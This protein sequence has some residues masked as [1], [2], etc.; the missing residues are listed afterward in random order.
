MATSFVPDPK[1]GLR[2]LGWVKQFANVALLSACIA[3]AGAASAGVSPQP[4]PTG[5][6]IYEVAQGNRGW[7]EIARLDG[8]ARRRLTQLPGSR[9]NRADVQ[10]TWSP[11][12]RRVAF[13]RFS[14][15]GRLPVTLYVVQL[16]GRGLRRIGPASSAPYVWS[17]NSRTLAFSGPS[18][19]C[20]PWKRSDVPL[21]VA[22]VNGAGLRR[23]SVVP[24][25]AITTFAEP[26]DLSPTSQTLLYIVKRYEEHECLENK[27]TGSDLDRIRIGEKKR[28]KLRSGAIGQAEWSPDGQKIAFLSGFGNRCAVFVSAAS[29]RSLRRLVDIP[30]VYEGCWNARDVFAWLPA[31]REIVVGEALSVAAYDV[32]TGSRRQIA[33]TSRQRCSTATYPCESRIVAVSRDGRYL[34][35]HEHQE[36]SSNISGRL[37]VVSTDG[38]QQWEL[39]YPKRNRAFAVFLNGRG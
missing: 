4:P 21:Y 2:R 37:Y 20:Y 16:N 27:L 24:R 25:T 32:E 26:T 1:I 6:I 9:S 34:A 29:D 13:V 38:T 12:G 10:A 7:L 15:G 11:D 22:A 39:P 30:W 28:T 3:A 23:L 18:P 31:G 33:Q 8:R 35:V 14:S 36:S 19:R 5:R 17:R